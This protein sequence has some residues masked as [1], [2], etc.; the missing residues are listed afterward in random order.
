MANLKLLPLGSG[1]K[2]TTYYK[3]HGTIQLLLIKFKFEY[4]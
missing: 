2:T 3:F 1:Q 4:F